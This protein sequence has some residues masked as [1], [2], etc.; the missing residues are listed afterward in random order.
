MFEPTRNA[1]E[2]PVRTSALAGPSSAAPARKTITY[3]DAYDREHTVKIDSGWEDPGLD[4]GTLAMST[5][6]RK[7]LKREQL[8][9]SFEETDH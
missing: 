3:N 2:I 6:Q 8:R 5:S 9:R 4:R 1:F 7:Y